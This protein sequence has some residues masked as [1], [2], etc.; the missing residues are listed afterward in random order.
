MGTYNS[1][2]HLTAKLQITGLV[3]TNMLLTNPKLLFGNDFDILK[4]LL[5]AIFSFIRIGLIIFF[6][7]GIRLQLHTLTVF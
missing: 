1:S 2:R 5:R 6:N 7:L 4:V 3:T